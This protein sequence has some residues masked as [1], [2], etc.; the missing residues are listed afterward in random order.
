MEPKKPLDEAAV[1]ALATACVEAQRARSVLLRAELA[2]ITKSFG[3]LGKDAR[4]TVIDELRRV[5][6]WDE[7]PERLM[8]QSRRLVRGSFRASLTARSLRG[9]RTHAPEWLLNSKVHCLP[10]IDR[11]E[12]PRPQVL[13]SEVSSGSLQPTAGVV[14]KPVRG[15]GSRGVF[16]VPSLVE[17]F[18]PKA[19]KTLHS[20]E[21]MLVAMRQALKAGDVSSDSWIME[22]LILPEH[23]SLN[24]GRDF[25][26]YSFYGR[27][28]L[29]L[30]IQRNPEIRYAWWDRKGRRVDTGKYSDKLMTGSGLVPGDVETAERVSYEIPAP[31]IRID[32][33]RSA[34]GLVFGEFTPRP[35]NYHKF[36]RSTDER[37]GRSFANA[38]GRLVADLLNGKRFDTFRSQFL[39][40]AAASRVS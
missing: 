1:L 19:E 37:L 20:W 6:P 13:L 4:K 24:S 14:V 8:R 33:L 36:N 38:E 3:R 15:A 21:E 16:L 18:Q 39:V 12:I 5:V 28:E 34:N 27:V 7:I 30:E 25:K 35:G 31:F 11:L 17:I 23:G 32:F 2:S 9:S 22:E 26:F 40:D 29:V 10:F